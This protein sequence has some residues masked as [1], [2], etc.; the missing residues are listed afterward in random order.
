VVDLQ[1]E[2][3]LGYTYS[4]AIVGLPYTSDFKSVVPNAPEASRPVTPITKKRFTSLSA[5]VRNSYA[6]EY[7]MSSDSLYDWITGTTTSAGET[8]LIEDKTITSSWTR[9]PTIFIRA[10]EPYPLNI[11]SIMIEME[12]G[13]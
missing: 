2:G 9:T 4:K 11:D 10:N 13:D 12:L 7:G 8:G 6:G 3:Q 5:F 1:P